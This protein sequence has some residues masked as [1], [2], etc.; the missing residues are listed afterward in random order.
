NNII[1]ANGG[2]DTLAGNG[3]NDT[4]VLATTQGTST[5]IDGGAGTDIIQAAGIANTWLV[6]GA[7]AGNLNGIAFS[8]IETLT[9]STAN[10]V[11]Q[12]RG[13][14]SIAGTVDGGT[15][16]NTLDYSLYS[17]GVTVN[18]TTNVATGTA[19]IANIQNIT[20]SPGNDSLTGSTAVNAIAGGGG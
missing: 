15:G 13:S 12:V 9:C 14:G 10:D 18:L 7:N 3:G 20:G 4:F 1:T 16:T 6:N 2:T 19:G 8:N 5:T 11:L 17:T